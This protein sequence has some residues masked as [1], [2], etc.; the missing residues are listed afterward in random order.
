MGY[1]TG[2]TYAFTNRGVQAK[3]PRASGVFTVY[4]ARRWVYVGESDDMH[5][6]LFHLLRD[7][8]DWGRRFGPLSF[9]VEEV[10][11][12]HRVAREQALVTELKPVCVDPPA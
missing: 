5:A 6:A 10:S 4:T 7:S 8:D 12:E 9:S 2:N 3:A 1:Q 11:A